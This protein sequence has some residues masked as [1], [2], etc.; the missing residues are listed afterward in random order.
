MEGSSNQQ[1]GGLT[2]YARRDSTGLQPDIGNK[3]I[4]IQMTDRIK[5]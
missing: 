2:D 3:S 1:E 4:P 5:V